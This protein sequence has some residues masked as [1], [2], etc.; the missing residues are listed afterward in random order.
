MN[1]G[2]AIKELRRKKAINQTE[3][4]LCCDIS[5][6]YLSQIE[7]NLKEPTLQTLNTIASEL[8][9]PLPFL[10]FLALDEQDIKPE[11]IEAYNYVAPSLKLMILSLFSND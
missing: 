10:F 5:Q 9:I 4:S 1:L 3:L 6:T 11:K 7:N 8:G 2:A